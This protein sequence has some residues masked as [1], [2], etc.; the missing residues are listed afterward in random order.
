MFL[1]PYSRAVRFN[2]S[3]FQGVQSMTTAPLSLTRQVS[4]DVLRCQM[5]QLLACDVDDSRA[6][7]ASWLLQAYIRSKLGTQV[8]SPKVGSVEKK[9][10]KYWMGKEK[11]FRQASDICT[12]TRL[13]HR[14]RRRTSTRRNPGAN[15]AGLRG[16]AV[17]EY[18][19]DATLSTPAQQE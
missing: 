13:Q 9:E 18:H 15:I 17:D 6:A 8:L 12:I 1:R 5:P 11:V 4:S 10:R 14:S 16:F 7:N 3:T 2:I 19:R